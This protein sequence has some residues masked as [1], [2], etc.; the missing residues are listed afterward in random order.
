M[1]KQVNFRE[2]IL[3]EGKEKGKEE[4]KQEERKIM[5]KVMLSNGMTVDQIAKAISISEDVVKSYI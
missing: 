2:E 4:G 3:E 5:I 1:L